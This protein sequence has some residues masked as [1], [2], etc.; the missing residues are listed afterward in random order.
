MQF[1]DGRVSRYAAAVLPRGT[2]VR[3]VT[4]TVKGQATVIVQ[5]CAGSENP[6]GF[7]TEPVEDTALPTVVK[8]KYAPGTQTAIAAKAF[9]AGAALYIAASGQVTDTVTGS[10]RATAMEAS[11]GANQLVEILIIA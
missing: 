1:N 10:I 9:A 2:A 7:L 3:H 11:S 4:G 8:L 5:A 6:E